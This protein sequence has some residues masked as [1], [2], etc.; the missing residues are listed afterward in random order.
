MNEEL[1]N[2]LAAIEDAENDF[3]KGIRRLHAMG[4]MESNATGPINLEDADAPV[5]TSFTGN[6]DDITAWLRRG[7][8]FTLPLMATV[9]VAI[10]LI[11]LMF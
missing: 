9:L 10:V 2:A 7:F 8:A 3:A 4:P 6:S 11:R 5:L 1:D